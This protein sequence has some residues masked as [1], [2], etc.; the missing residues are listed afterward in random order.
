M[1]KSLA[2]HLEFDSSKMWVHLTDGRVL[3]VPLA[4]FPR[5]QNAAAA[6][7]VQWTISGDGTGLHWDALNE[8]ISVEHLM[9]GY[10]DRKRLAASK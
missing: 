10:G 3:G 1:S 6:E 8:D 9:L 2:S 5:L 4:F 7:L